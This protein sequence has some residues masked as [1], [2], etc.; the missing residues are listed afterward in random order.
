MQTVIG[1]DYG[2]LE[3]RAVLVDCA[4]G[5]ILCESKHIYESG[6]IGDSLASAKDYE[7]TLINLLED[8]C[9]NAEKECISAICVDATS[10]TIVPVDTNGI[11]LCYYPEFSDNEHA[12]IKLWKRHTAMRQ[13]DE[14][15]KLALKMDEPFIKRTGNSLSCESM[16]PKILETRDMAPDVYLKTDAF[17]D[18]CDFLTFKLSGELCRNIGSMSMKS[19]WAEDIGFP[20]KAY[21]NALRSGFYSEYIHF[22]R[23]KVVRPGEKIGYLKE[24]LCE[25]LGIKHRVAVS[26]GMIDGYTSVVALGALFPGDVSLAMG[27]STVISLQTDRMIEIDG[28]CGVAKDIYSVGCYG[29][30][31][32][33]NCTG[34]MLGAYVQKYIGSN[35]EKEAEEQGKS[36]HSILC[37]K[38]NEPWKCSLV[39]SD[40]WNGSRNVP[41]DLDAKG[42]I[43]GIRTDTKAEDVY[44]SLLQGIVCGTRAILEKCEKYGICVNRILATGG[45]A[46]KNQIIMQEYANILNKSVYVADVK[47]GSVFGSAIYAS[48]AAG[49]YRDVNEASKNMSVKEFKEY[50]PDNEHRGEYE[51]IYKRNMALRALTLKID[52]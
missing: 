45:L 41:C 32:G 28:V 27:T 52:I 14:A 9:K 31:A 18:L 42:V 13:A 20:S 16:L 5:K 50:R 4:D 46:V 17:L 10:C 3:A 12:Y 7:K 19:H 15:L 22:L 8:I 49:V 47:E 6:I 40:W 30:E 23:G 35:I 37:K 25:H 21:L 11:P 44:L 39:S 36:I 43:W 24:E 29:I 48:V 26:S 51:N 33:Q 38:I 2:T 34:D 1:I